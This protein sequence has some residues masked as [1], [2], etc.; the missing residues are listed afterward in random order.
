VR[1]LENAIIQMIA[2]SRGDTLVA[3]LLPKYLQEQKKTKPNSDGS[4]LNQTIS[5]SEKTIIK[6]TLE[7]CRWQQTDAAKLLNIPRTTLRSKMKKYG[8]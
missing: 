3:S 5:S 2:L 7:K 1:E 8:L 6:E 4:S